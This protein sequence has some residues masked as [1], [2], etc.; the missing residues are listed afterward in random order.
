MTMVQSLE[1]ENSLELLVQSL[2]KENSLEPLIPVQVHLDLLRH[3]KFLK[4]CFLAGL[5]SRRMLLW[6]TKKII[7]HHLQ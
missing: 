7:S 3:S 6:K 5:R 2:E 1:K 4:I